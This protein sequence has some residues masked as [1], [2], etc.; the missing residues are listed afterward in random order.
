MSRFASALVIVV[1]TSLVILLFPSTA[2]SSEKHEKYLNAICAGICFD[3]DYEDYLLSDEMRSLC[4]KHTYEDINSCRKLC[5]EKKIAEVDKNRL[6]ERIT[7]FMDI[8]ADCLKDNR[9]CS[10]F[11]QPDF[12]KAIDNDRD[13]VQVFTNMRFA[14]VKGKEIVTFSCPA[15]IILDKDGTKCV[16]EAGKEFDS[17]QTACIDK[18]AAVDNIKTLLDLLPDEILDEIKKK[19]QEQISESIDKDASFLSLSDKAKENLKLLGGMVSTQFINDEALAQ[20]IY[21]NLI[22]NTDNLRQLIKYLGKNK[23]ERLIEILETLTSEAKTEPTAVEEAGEEVKD[24]MSLDEYYQFNSKVYNNVGQLCKSEKDAC[25]KRC[26]CGDR[27]WYSYDCPPNFPGYVPCTIDC[28]VTAGCG[29]CRKDADCDKF[30]RLG[31]YKARCGIPDGEK[32]GICRLVK[33]IKQY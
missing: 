8:C 31:G 10:V 23:T 26:V 33:P 6:P 30:G 18:K 12:C 13:M 4:F 7:G 17:L 29:T 2:S 14:D 24:N 25:Q 1:F 32:E 21:T 20:L 16:C 22:Y 28:Q 15:G 11:Y 19:A 9:Y 5:L 3:C 27:R